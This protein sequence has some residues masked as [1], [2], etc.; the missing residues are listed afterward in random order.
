M[1]GH[2][3]WIVFVVVMAALTLVGVAASKGGIT[4]TTC[5]RDRCRTV[6]NAI[7][8]IGTLPGRVSAPRSGRFFTISLRMETN[9]RPAGWKVVYEAKAPDPRAGWA[10]PLVHGHAL[11]A[12][13]T[14]CATALRRGGP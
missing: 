13:D 5:G 8:G 14:R 2:R 11:G 7:S 6:T 3:A 1:S 12:A 4:T 10:R 9:G